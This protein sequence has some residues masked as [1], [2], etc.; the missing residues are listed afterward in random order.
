[1]NKADGRGRQEKER[2]ASISFGRKSSKTAKLKG[3]QFLI[4]ESISRRTIQVAKEPRKQKGKLRMKRLI[5]DS[6]S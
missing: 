6:N 1:L 4:V 3:S 5:W 2:N